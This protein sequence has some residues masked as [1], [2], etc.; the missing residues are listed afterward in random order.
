MPRPEATQEDE[1]EVVK[2]KAGGFLEAGLL[3]PTP[4]D[5]PEGLATT[6]PRL[7]AAE[8]MAGLRMMVLLSRELSAISN[9]SDV[10]LSLRS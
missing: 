10:V 4:D 8:C 3:L 1:D 5:A 6:G 9:G 7:A 2:T